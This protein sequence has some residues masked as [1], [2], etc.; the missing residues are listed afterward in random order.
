MTVLHIEH[1][2]PNYEGWKKAFDSDPMNRK[3]SGVK[4]YRVYRSTKEPNLVAIDLE[5]DDLA[6]AEKMLAGLK[7]MWQ[8]VEGSVM[9]SPKACL[10]EV[11]ETIEF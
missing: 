1:P 8:K 5:F 4:K 9:T 3:N 11:M 6:S 2:V 10:F 7:I